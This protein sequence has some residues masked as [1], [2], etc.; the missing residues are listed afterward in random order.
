MCGLLVHAY[1]SCLL[2]VQVEVTVRC[3]A[4]DELPLVHTLTSK[5]KIRYVSVV[6]SCVAMVTTYVFHRSFDLTMKSNGELL[7]S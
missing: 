2:V 7:V 6:P 1:S 4:E 5:T 3:T